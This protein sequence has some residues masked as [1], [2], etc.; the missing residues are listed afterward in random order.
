[1]VKTF[2][3]LLHLL[4]GSLLMLPAVAAHA[5]NDKWYR[6]E[7]L[8]FDNPTGADTEEWKHYRRSPTLTKQ[9]TW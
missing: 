4:L 3:V 1:M 9:P 7:L 5:E 8:V 2:A 6:V